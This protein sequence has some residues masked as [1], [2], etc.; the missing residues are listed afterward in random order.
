MQSENMTRNIFKYPLLVLA[1]SFGFGLSVQAQQ[2]WGDSVFTELPARDYAVT[3]EDLPYYTVQIPL[4]SSL[5]QMPEVSL[6]YPEYEALAAD[7]V[8]L[9]RRCGYDVP[10]EI[11]PLVSYGMSRKKGVLDVSFCPIVYRDGRYL[12]LVS[13]K[14]VLA[15][16]FSQAAKVQTAPSAGN[17]AAARWASTSVL[18]EGRWVKIRVRNEGIYELTA[19]QLSGMG[20]KDISRVKVY[21]YG[22]RIQDEDWN[23]VDADRVPDDL[24]E[25]PVYRRSGSLLF[26]AEGTV[27][28]TW[29]SATARWL[30]QGQPYSRYSHYF[31]T[32]G[33]AP[34]QLARLEN[35]EA[36][37]TPISSVSHHALLDNDAAYFYHGGREI[38]DAAT[39][40]NGGSYTYKLTAPDIVEGDEAKVSV[41]FAVANSSSSTN[42]ALSMNGA[43][44]GKFNVR[45]YG[46]E[47]NA[48]ESRQTFSTD[49]L[50]LNNS[51]TFSPLASSSVSLTARLNYICLTYKRRLKADV[52]PYAFTVGKGGAATLQIANATEQTRL[53]ALGDADMPTAEVP[54]RLNGATYEATVPD[55][56]R[57]YVI[58]DLVRS[59]SA[60]EVVGVVNNQNL[61]ATEPVDMVILIPTSGKLRGQAER[62]A[63]AHRAKSG[64]RVQ[65]VTAG[66]IYNEF[67]SGTPDAT[68][69]RR[70]LKM[71]YDRAETEADMPR[72]LLLFGDCAWD[73]RM[74]T[75]DWSG[76]SPDDYL[77][78]FEVND[79]YNNS[80][81]NSISLGSLNSY[82]T[83]DY[84]GWLD[85]S[86]G[87]NYS[88]NKLDV[89]I[90]RLPC[91]D[92]ATAR[93]MVDKI[94]AYL[95]NEEAGAWKNKVYL[96]GDDINNTLHMTGS[97][98]VATSIETASADRL[99]Q[100][101]VYWD[102]YPRTYAAT[103]FTYPEAT[104]ELHEYMTSG[105]LIFNYIGH[106]SPDQISHSGVLFKEDYKLSSNGRLPLWIFASCE[107]S[108][109]DVRREDIGRTALYNPTGGAVA[110]LSASR[111]VYSGSNEALNMAF[112]SNLLNEEEAPYGMGEALRRAKVSLVEN[113]YNG[114]RS[115]NKLKYALLGDP[116]LPLLFPRRRVV[117]DSINGEKLVAGKMLELSAGSMARISG[118]VV[119]N[120]APDA[121]FN[122][123]VTATMMDRKEKIT[124]RN[125]SS[126]KS[127]MVYEDRTK[128]I[129]EG[130]DSVVAGRF[131]LNI[132][133]PRDISYSDFSGR[134]TLYAVSADRTIEANGFNEQ[135]CLNG[136]DASLPADTISPSAYVFLDTSDF[137]NGGITSPNPLF[138]AQVSDDIGINVSRSALG[139]EMELT[140]D[141]KT[142]ESIVLNNHFTYAFGDFRKGTVS[143]PLSGLAPGRHTLSFRVWDVNNNSTTSHLDF[144]VG[145]DAVESF[146]VSVT[147]NP[148]RT[149]TNFVARLDGMDA[150]GGKLTLEVYDV[151][152][153]KVWST[154]VLSLSSYAVH[155]WN[156]CGSGGEPLPSGL[157]LYRAV[158]QTSAGTRETDAK[159]IIILRQ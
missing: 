76:Y 10:D 86:E 129:F 11:K 124:C 60:P 50:S 23:F 51:F 148:A 139:H 140:L 77:L 35:V 57:R 19:S 141:G 120:N 38:Y 83:D 113:A 14:I 26:F 108:P 153:R 125:N 43:N 82:V 21:G 135:F 155:P 138:V 96:L 67:S 68:A 122:G 56:S 18:S 4:E 109:Y 27:R 48:Y 72:Y 49:K 105:A 126:D 22:G 63:E 12:R 55:G 102:V 16:N 95:N 145:A 31:V 123:E 15:S 143:Y 61:H 106:G 115:I 80:G 154:S 149:S 42:V 121:S 99:S 17:T 3:A 156:L 9:V 46:T 81:V 116:A 101:R 111:A 130:T 152:G 8:R 28:W 33:D 53:W 150:D 54:G 37:G 34:Q 65:V 110:V 1:L 59:Y 78:A 119:Q 52:S 40:Q 94:I 147:D 13:C 24:N 36:T 45:K 90:G 134:L 89:G 93:V 58:V 159:K 127:T 64:L 79:D 29:D 98:R 30:H 25:V 137:V 39:I 157:Y 107:I 128:T 66:E 114:D 32:E 71:L 84:Y 69:Y 103:G 70:Y 104:K 20:F 132:P 47:E 73:N 75:S 158:W 2:S 6:H 85:D 44:L 151:S 74:V 41:G 88:Y 131:T 112:V 62:L 146:G 136:T 100:R 144:Y 91:T 133:I 117:V 87:T 118:Y 5:G 97:E 142:A 7:E 92:D